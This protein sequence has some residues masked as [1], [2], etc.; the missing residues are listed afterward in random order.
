MK[1]M[2][3]LL[4]YL[5]MLPFQVASQTC[6]WSEL[7]GKDLVLYRYGR[8]KDGI[9]TDYRFTTDFAGQPQH[10]APVM[11]DGV[12][13]NRART[14]RNCTCSGGRFRRWRARRLN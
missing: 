10:K 1:Q 13:G 5:L 14:T 12:M 2:F 11:L 3:L 8:L 9:F 4:L 7:I 6:E